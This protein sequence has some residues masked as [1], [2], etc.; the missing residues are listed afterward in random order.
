MTN[1]QQV[2]R[3]QLE[4][5]E[6]DLS[7]DH[8]L[9]YGSNTNLLL[10]G[11]ALRVL[12][13]EF[14]QLNGK[15]EATIAELLDLNN[16]YSREIQVP[17]PN[18]DQEYHPLIVFRKSSRDP[19][20]LTFENKAVTFYCP[21][22]NRSWRFDHN[23][24][25]PDR[26]QHRSL[27]ELEDIG[28]ELYA[29]LPKAIRGPFHILDF[30]FTG[31]KLKL[32]LLSLLLCS[33]VII[34]FDLLIPVLTR[35][36]VGRVLPDAD[37]ELL[38]FSSLIAGVV[39]AGL[40]IGQYL[41]SRMLLRIETIGERKLQIALWE[42]LV[43]LPIPFISQFT[44]GDL[45]SRVGAITQLQRLLS[46]VLL[47]SAINLLFSFLYFFLMFKYDKV[48]AYWA[49][50]FTLISIVGIIALNLPQIRLQKPLQEGGSEITNFAL[51][52][53]SGLQQIRACGSEPFVLIRWLREVNQYARTQL[54]INQY[55]DALLLYSQ[56]VNSLGLLLVFAILTRRI[57]NSTSTIQV[58]TYI[59]AF[60]S[61]NSAFQSFNSGLS[62]LVSQIA[63]VAGQSIVL[64]D[65][66]K[67]LM[68]QSYESGFSTSSIVHE[69]Q[70][71]IEFKGIS[72]KFPT[73]VTPIFQ[74]ITFATKANSHTAITG[75]TGSG[76]TTLIRMILG[77]IEPDKGSILV[78]G[79]PLTKLA[80]RQYRRQIGVVMQSIRFNSGSIYEIIR[81][82]SPVTKDFI[83]DCLEKVGFATE[84]HSLPMQLDTF[85][86]EGGSNLS[87]GQ[88]QKLAIARALVHRPRLLLMDEATSALDANSQDAITRMAK[89]LGIT[90]ITVAHRL[91]TIIDADQLIVIDQGHVIETGTPQQLTSQDGYF[92]RSM[93]ASS[94]ESQ[95]HG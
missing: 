20:L 87:G 73:A 72:L 43:K 22:L 13:A 77:F 37:T 35:F 74:D 42:H 25:I 50:G 83:W 8:E 85:I 64:W 30:I 88:R 40:A 17:N 47:S 68:Y 5:F 56:T 4:K 60:L 21:I 44:T 33:A 9:D 93:R 36:L 70:G 54:R 3:Q 19:L 90:R 49:I 1:H 53:I 65:R 29:P 86:S 75:P 38:L 78:D 76:K 32:S 89:E 66:A 71:A 41:Q 67:P 95:P 12:G 81:S 26:D 79:L 24:I 16:L 10:I 28:I 69:L 82:G 63:T 59:I 52:A 7:F 45:A 61:F 6:K 58:S 18:S 34:G 51:Q 94:Q 48:L 92:A 14:Y 46:N 31:Q 80:I 2:T 11:K 55:G 39:I 15:P 23:A 84:V 57:L 27:P 91:S 62:S